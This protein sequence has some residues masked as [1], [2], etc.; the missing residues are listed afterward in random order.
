MCVET[1]TRRTLV[2]S[3]TT[4][5]STQR[6]P[7]LLGQTVVCIGGSAGIGLQ[8]ARR[9]RVEGADVVL[10]WRNPDRLKAAAAEVDAQRTAAFDA[11]DSAALHDFFEGLATPIDPYAS[12]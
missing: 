10:T 2:S 5:A 11:T 6:L 9:A 12:T 8:T 1:T 3:R 7:E 4:S